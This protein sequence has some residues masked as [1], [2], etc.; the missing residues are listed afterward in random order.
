MF[1]TDHSSSTIFWGCV[2]P[3]NIR[4]REEFSVHFHRFSCLSIVLDSTF[5]LLMSP[6]PYLITAAFLDLIVFTT[7]SEFSS[8]FRFFYF[9]Q[10]YSFVTFSLS[11]VF[12]LSVSNISKYLYPSPIYFMTS[13]L[14]C[15]IASLLDIIPLFIIT[16]AHLPTLNSIP[17]SLLNT[18]TVLTSVLIC[19][20]QFRSSIKRRWS[21]FL[22]RSPK[23]YP[24]LTSLRTNSTGINANTK[25][26]GEYNSYNITLILLL[27]LINFC[28]LDVTF[29]FL[30][31][32]F[33]IFSPTQNIIIHFFN[34]LWR[35]MFSYSLFM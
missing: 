19:V 17:M 14:C 18:Q 2:E 32:D 6:W 27:L 16:V 15:C 5:V 9:P 11:K 34:Q 4:S 31:Y 29:V 8:D 24:D 23:W 30:S 3:I 33:C 35:I 22:S 25:S 13:I 7:L 12:N 21:K 20:S 28:P 26:N 10:K 1:N